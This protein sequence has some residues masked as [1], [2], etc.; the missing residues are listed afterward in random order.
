LRAQFLSVCGAGTGAQ[1]ITE[2]Y[3][4]DNGSTLVRIELASSAPDLTFASPIDLFFGSPY[5]A[6]SASGSGITPEPGGQP[7]FYGFS[8]A[9]SGDARGVADFE[10]SDGVPDLNQWQFGR[11]G[12]SVNPSSGA[13]IEACK[14]TLTELGMKNNLTDAPG[15]D[16]STAGDGISCSIGYVGE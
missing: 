13:T 6:Q 1:P 11:Y 8:W 4:E 5:F 14:V 16:P 7:C 12:F 3:L 9:K 10:N 15:W 2:Q